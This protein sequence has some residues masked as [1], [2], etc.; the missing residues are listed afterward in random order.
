MGIE[1][2]LIED[3]LY[4]KKLLSLIGA[5]GLALIMSFGF[6]TH[7]TFAASTPASIVEK[8]EEVSPYAASRYVV[9]SIT[10]NG[11]V[12]PDQSYLYTDHHGYRG[13]IYLVIH[14]TRNS[15]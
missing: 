14:M 1:P 12:I 15:V 5:T 3:S 6:T 13:Y 9:H 8:V 2:P 10:K 7:Q 4:M 11:S